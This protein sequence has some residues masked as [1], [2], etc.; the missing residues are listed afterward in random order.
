MVLL[1]G[2]S[3]LTHQRVASVLEEQPIER[4]YRVIQQTQVS[5]NGKLHKF[6]NDARIL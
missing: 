3:T 6:P 1:T 4:I 5:Y 2:C